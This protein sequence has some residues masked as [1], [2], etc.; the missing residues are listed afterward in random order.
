VVQNV[1]F[2]KQKKR[3]GKKKAA[4]EIITEDAVLQEVSVSIIT[5][6]SFSFFATIE[7]KMKCIKFHKK[8]KL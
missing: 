1:I 2:Q 5:G 6:I 8:N 7:I 3:K 4:E